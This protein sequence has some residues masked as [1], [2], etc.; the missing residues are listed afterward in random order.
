MKNKTYAEFSGVKSISKIVRFLII[1][2]I[3]SFTEILYSLE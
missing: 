1:M 2:L 3:K